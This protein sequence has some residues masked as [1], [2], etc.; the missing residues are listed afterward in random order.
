MSCGAGQLQKNVANC[1]SWTANCPG[2]TLFCLAGFLGKKDGSASR[3][4]TCDHSINSRTLYQLSYRGS[5]SKALKQGA[6]VNDRVGRCRW[7][8][9]NKRSPPL[10]SPFLKKLFHRLYSRGIPRKIRSLCAHAIAGADPLPANPDPN[11]RRPRSGGVAFRPAPCRFVRP[12]AKG[13]PCSHPPEGLEQSCQ[14]P[15]RAKP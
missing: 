1:R 12:P 15:C 11:V 2:L 9:Y 10:P 4:R 7:R 5:P 6:V 8:A 13:R 14:V 3:T